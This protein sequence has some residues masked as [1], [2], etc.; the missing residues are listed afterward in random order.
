MAT[1][2][3]RFTKLEAELK[4]I[5]AKTRLAF[6][7]GG[8]LATTDELGLHAAQVDTIVKKA[9][10]QRAAVLARMR[11]GERILFGPDGAPLVPGAARVPEEVP[12][13]KLGPPAPASDACRCTDYTDGFARPPRDDQHEPGCR[14]YA[15]HVARGKA[16]EEAA[17]AALCAFCGLTEAEGRHSSKA[18]P[19]T[20]HGFRAAV[21]PEERESAARAAE[22][23]R[24][25]A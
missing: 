13:V 11:Q 5:D 4:K 24:S 18:H 7:L 1:L 8:L 9:I 14:Y 12:T 20:W 22:L 15:A 16:A 25:P 17:Q 19:N 10:A 3:D 2:Q 23:R 21:T 6:L